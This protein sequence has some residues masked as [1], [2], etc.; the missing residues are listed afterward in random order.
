MAATSTATASTSRC[1][2]RGWPH[3]AAPASR[4]RC[5]IIDLRP[6]PTGR[7]RR[8]LHHLS[9]SMA[10]SHLVDTTPRSLSTIAA[11]RGLRPRL[12]ADLE[13]PARISRTAPHLL[14]QKCVRDTPSKCHRSRGRSKLRRDC[15]HRSIDLLRG[16]VLQAWAEKPDGILNV[17]LLDSERSCRSTGG[18]DRRRRTAALSG[19]ITG[20]LSDLRP[21]Y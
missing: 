21:R 14:L 20:L 18:E 6:S 1:G 10:R 3:R 7:L 5:A 16:L 15:Y 9:Y 12:T 13:E 8:V 19:I 4:A 17:N 11:R 2:W